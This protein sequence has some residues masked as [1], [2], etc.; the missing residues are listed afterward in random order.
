MK[1]IGAKIFT[2]VVIVACMGLT[3][4]FLLAQRRKVSRSMLT[5]P[6]ENREVVVYGCATPVAS[7]QR[8]QG[9]ESLPVF[10]DGQE[11][12]TV[13]LVDERDGKTYRVRKLADEQCWLID[14]LRFGGWPDQCLGKTSFD[15]TQTGV[16]NHLGSGSWGDC[17][18]SDQETAGYFYNYSALTQGQVGETI[19]GLCPGG[20]RVPS[21]GESGDFAQLNAIYQGK[22]DRWQDEWRSSLAGDAIYSGE[23]FGQNLFGYYWSATGADE[24]KAYNL[25]LA[26]GSVD[27]LSAHDVTI[28]FLGRCVYD[29]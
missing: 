2:L 29:R 9:C 21:G 26:P 11:A 23:L 13:C 14:D 20:W 3:G 7:L 6:G 8:W 28:G 27:A 25:Q 22:I 5:R 12:A 4:A 10:E 17:R 19:Q 16:T 1:N 15:G 18:V 24:R